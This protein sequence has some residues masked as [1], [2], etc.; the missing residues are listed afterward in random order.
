MTA[1]T[2]GRDTGG[3]HPFIHTLAVVGVPE[4]GQV[5]SGS[6]AVMTHAAQ[7]IPVPTDTSSA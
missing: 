6:G 3:P 5:V 4:P 2:R 1:S 7:G